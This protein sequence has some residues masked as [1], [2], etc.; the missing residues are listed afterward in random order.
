MQ[1]PPKK[2]DQGVMHFPNLDLQNLCNYEDFPPFQ[3]FRTKKVLSRRTCLRSVVFSN[4]VRRKEVRLANIDS[5]HSQ[6]RYI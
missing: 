3:V 4:I 6:G 1:I 5:F 2:L